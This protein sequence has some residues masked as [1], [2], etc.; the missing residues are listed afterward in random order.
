[1]EA[2]LYYTPPPEEVF[3]EVKEKA[4]EVWKELNSHPSYEKEKLDRI[5]DLPN[6]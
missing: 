4:T 2:E 5:T 3:N 1:M 6:V